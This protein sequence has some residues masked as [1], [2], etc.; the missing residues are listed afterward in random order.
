MRWESVVVL[1]WSFW[2]VGVRVT[3]AWKLEDVLRKIVGH[4]H[5]IHILS[6]HRKMGILSRHLSSAWHGAAP[7]RPLQDLIEYV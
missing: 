4:F 5:H 2:S 7:S 1:V 6:E 3:V